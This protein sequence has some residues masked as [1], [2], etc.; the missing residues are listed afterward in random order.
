MNALRSEEAE[1]VLR[2]AV[3]ALAVVVI[4][5]DA[6]ALELR[7]KEA[8]RKLAAERG[9]RFLIGFVLAENAPRLPRRALR[10][11]V[12]AGNR[13]SPARVLGIERW[14]DLE[15]AAGHDEIGSGIGVARIAAMPDAE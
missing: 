13:V 7:Q 14:R 5:F 12:E 11:V 15:R 2:E 10:V 9:E 8:L 3:E 1:L 6:D 4:E